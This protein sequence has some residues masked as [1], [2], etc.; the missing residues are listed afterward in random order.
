M[1]RRQLLRGAA[2][3]LP[4]GV[5]GCIADSAAEPS[6]GA[7]ATS[8]ETSQSATATPTQTDTPADTA[9]PTDAPTP[10]ETPTATATPDETAT[11]TSTPVGTATITA[12]DPEVD[13]Q[14]VAERDDGPQFRPETFEIAA[15]DTVKW[16]LADPGF[17][18]VP[19][20]TPDASEWEGTPGD[21]KDVYDEGDTHAYTFE[22]A[23]DYEYTAGPYRGLDLYGT[24]TVTE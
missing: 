17:N 21:A 22:V 24:F 3:V 4:L 14:V 13:Q 20:E 2:V 5:T 10:T 12:T 7:A 8:T 16:V 11:D 19:A 1:E 9:T 15:G 23:G 6:D 18:I